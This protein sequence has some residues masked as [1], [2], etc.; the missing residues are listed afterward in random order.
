MRWKR[1]RHNSSRP[2]PSDF[3]HNRRAAFR[4]LLLPAPWCRY[5]IQRGNAASV[6]GTCAPSAKVDDIFLYRVGL[7]VF[8]VVDSNFGGILRF[9]LCCSF[10]LDSLVIFT[11]PTSSRKLTLQFTQRILRVC[12]PFQLSDR[13]NVP[14]SSG[15]FRPEPGGTPSRFAPAPC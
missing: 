14:L 10:V 9:S 1:K 13:I 7:V 12:L 6:T 11:V 5:P 2:R 15:G 4:G 3:C 8:G